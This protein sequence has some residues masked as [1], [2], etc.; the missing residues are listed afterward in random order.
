[1]RDDGFGGGPWESTPANPCNS[2]QLE[3]I[4]TLQKQLDEAVALLRDLALLVVVGCAIKREAVTTPVVCSCILGH[5][6]WEYPLDYSTQDV[7]EDCRVH[8]SVMP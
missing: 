6:D 8:G 5:P 3:Q 2:F 7:P 1:M 4:A